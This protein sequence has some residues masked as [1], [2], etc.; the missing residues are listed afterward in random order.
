MAPIN[1]LNSASSGE[2]I[3]LCRIGKQGDDSGVTPLAV[4][5]VCMNLDISELLT[6][7]HLLFVNITV[8]VVLGLSAHC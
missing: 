2:G 6:Q 7:K 8:S 5:V 4:L 3:V 1:V